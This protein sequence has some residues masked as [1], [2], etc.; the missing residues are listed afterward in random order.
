MTKAEL[1]A[2]DLL[3]TRV[4]G[5]LNQMTVEQRRRVF[6]LL[7]FEFCDFC[8]NGEANGAARCICPKRGG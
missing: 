5:G 8:V 4:A 1:D 6:Q 3:A 2:A 7:R